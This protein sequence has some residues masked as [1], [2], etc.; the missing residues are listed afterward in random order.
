MLQYVVISGMETTI[1]EKKK[2]VS[3]DIATTQKIIL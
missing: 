1:L 2:I 3:S